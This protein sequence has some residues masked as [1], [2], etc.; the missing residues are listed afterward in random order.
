MREINLSKVACY[1]DRVCDY[2]PIVSTASNFVDLFEKLAFKGFDSTAIHQNRYFTYI[3]NKPTWRCVA[4][5]IPILG[6]I[7][8]AI[9]DL[10]KYGEKKELKKKQVNDEAMIRGKKVPADHKAREI[11]KQQIHSEE[12]K[13]H[14]TDQNNQIEFF[15]NPNEAQWDE[16]VEACRL[17][18]I[19]ILTNQDMGWDTF[20]QVAVNND[21][22]YRLIVELSN[23]HAE[24]YSEK[25]TNM[26]DNQLLNE[27][28][29]K[30]ELNFYFQERGVEDR[31]EQVQSLKTLNECISFLNDRLEE[32]K[33]LPEKKVEITALLDEI[34]KR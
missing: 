33:D 10:V 21:E 26:D 17:T 2:I 32:V 8:I 28:K 25:I 4:L 14:I 13:S 6:N 22:L 24:E 27:V 5:L 7:I 23:K 34:A 20:E 3:D 31:I 18:R 9:D 16:I 19:L 29:E 12:V 11:F 15:K 30:F 1:A